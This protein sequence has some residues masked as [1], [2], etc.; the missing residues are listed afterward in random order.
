MGKLGML[1]RGYREET[2]DVGSRRWGGGK[3]GTLVRG[4][5][6][7]GGG[8]RRQRV[9]DGWGMAGV[10]KPVM[11]IARPL[12]MPKATQ[13]KEQVCCNLLLLSN[14]Q[15]CSLAAAAAA[16]KATPRRP[17][18]PTLVC[19]SSTH[20]HHSPMSRSVLSDRSCASSM[21]SALYFRSRKSSWKTEEEW[22]S[23]GNG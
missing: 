19:R 17:H 20:P 10:R 3:W 23:K 4:Q 6:R 13:Q 18:T 11:C 2:G 1:L 15:L 9:N 8:G 21:T 7:R 5:G 16:A 22:G 14:N 12:F